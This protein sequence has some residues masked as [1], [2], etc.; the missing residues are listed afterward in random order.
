MYDI[1]IIGG[2][3]AGLTAGIYGARAGK[4]VVIYE[5]ESFGGQIINTPEIENYPGIKN[6]S[7]YEFSENLYKQTTAL[8]A[9]FVFDGVSGVK[10]LPD[11]SFEL[12]VEFGDNVTSKT[13]IL[14]CGA[15]HRELG[16]AAEQKYL[17][18]GISY[19]ATCD[20]SFFKGKDVSVAGGG[21]T[22]L[23]EA[24]YLSG[25]CNKVYLI[26]RRDEFRAESA[27]VKK[28]EA[29]PNIE[30][31]LSAEVKELLGDDKLNGINVFMK[32]DESVRKLDVEALFVA[33]GQVPSNKPFA[34]LVEL[35]EAGYVVAGE[36]CKTS[37]EGV[38]A[39][40]DGRT[41]TLRQLSTAAA[42]GAVA[43]VNACDYLLSK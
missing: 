30:F 41:K 39:A 36:D 5:G 37:C 22:A 29:I 1:A 10:K 19:C 21:N 23:E 4:K 7:G 27:L 40:G 3:T 11:G 43:A 38:F 24:I 28:A 14:A 12:Q 32:K 35:D 34:D 13:V 18:R 9:E 42:D 20:G 16:L 15:K 25:L 17:G 33:I 6:I 2:G 31:V 26:H 8:G